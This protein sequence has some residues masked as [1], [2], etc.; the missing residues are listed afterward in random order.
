VAELATASPSRGGHSG[1][2]KIKLRAPAAE[3]KAKA[4]LIGFWL[5]R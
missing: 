5:N 4:A 1:A 2:I 3:G